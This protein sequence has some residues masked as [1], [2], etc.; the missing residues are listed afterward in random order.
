LGIKAAVT[1]GE[2]QGIELSKVTPR[3]RLNPIEALEMYTRAGALASHEEDLIG[4][5]R[6]GALADFVVLSGDPTTCDP[7]QL[8]NLRVKMTVVN[9]KVVHCSPD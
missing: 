9:G 3:E 2:E 7:A 6:A 1:R 5:L 4:S 8:D